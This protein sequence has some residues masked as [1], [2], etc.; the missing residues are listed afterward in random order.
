L[1]DWNNHPA[2]RSSE[3]E[4]RTMDQI[5]NERATAW[6][7]VTEARKRGFE[8]ESLIVD[9]V[10]LNQQRWIFFWRYRDELPCS[11]QSGEEEGTLHYNMQGRISGLP[12]RL[13]GAEISFHGAWSEAGTLETIE[14]ASDLV[15]AWLIDGKEVDDLPRRLA[16]RWQI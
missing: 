9:S 3:K 12:N 1:G 6:E 16:R 11:G 14:Q 4:V 5:E 7:I 10:F 8:L 2:F 15:K 13:R